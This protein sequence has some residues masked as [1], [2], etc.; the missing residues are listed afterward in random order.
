MAPSVRAPVETRSRRLRLEARKRPY[1]ATIEKGLAVGYH[2]PVGG[3]AGTWWART[4]I[5]GKSGYPY[6]E[7]ALVRAD[8]HTE[9]NGETVLDW[10]Q[11]Q[12]AAREWAARQTGAGPLTVAKTCDRYLEHLRTR[13]GDRAAKDAEGRI[14]KHILAGLGRMLVAEL[15]ADDVRA[16]HASMV[17]GAHAEAQRRS[18]DSANRVLTILK[19]ALNSAFQDG[20]AADDRAW[21]RVRAFHGVSEARKVILADNELQRLVDA[22]PPALRQLVAAGALTGARLGELT[23]ARVCNLDTEAATFWVRGKTGSREVHLNADTLVLFRQLASGKRADEPLFVT[24]D[25][26]RWTP[27]LHTRRVAAAVQHAGLD[28]ATTFYALRHTYISRA[29]RQGVPAKAVADHCGTSLRMI[30]ANYAKFFP[31]DRARYAAIAA[32][33]LRL[34]SADGKVVRLQSGGTRQC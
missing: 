9:A 17:H 11:A 27:A 1:W 15:T 16:W 34:G 32:P 8:D 6:K 10:K 24:E 12:V 2:R 29:L 18:R 14:R 25:G 7:A 4:V 5:P 20:L 21:R 19:A 33:E 30:E 13:K 26:G 28:P 31:E 22:C 3:G 23:G